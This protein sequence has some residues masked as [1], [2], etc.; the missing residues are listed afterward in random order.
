MMQQERN[1]CRTLWG[2]VSVLS[3]GG[4]RGQ[5]WLTWGGD[6]E[7]REPSQFSQQP[8]DKKSRRGFQPQGRQGTCSRKLD[9][10]HGAMAG[11]AGGSG[12]TCRHHTACIS[13]PEHV[14]R[15]AFACLIESGAEHRRREK[16]GY[17]L[18]TGAACSVP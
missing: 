12:A 4:E 13:G 8:N 5:G 17:W 18:L 9:V 3:G 7:N 2:V 1:S 10:A 11:T 15:T 14:S 6:T 16:W